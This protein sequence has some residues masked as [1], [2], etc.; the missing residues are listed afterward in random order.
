M[1]FQQAGW[2]R[3]SWTASARFSGAGARRFWPFLDGGRETTEAATHVD[4][5]G[6]VFSDPG[7]TPGASTIFARKIDDL[8]H[9]SRRLHDS[10]TR[11]RVPSAAWGWLDQKSAL[12]LKEYKR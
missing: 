11:G 5:G 10:S 1:S 4:S 9:F 8:A 2:R 3:S 12:S 6:D 7:A